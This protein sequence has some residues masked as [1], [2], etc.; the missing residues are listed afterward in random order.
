MVLILN[1]RV[2]L[3]TL[4]SS[5]FIFKTIVVFPELSSP[6]QPKKPIIHLLIRY[7]D[8]DRD[9]TVDGYI[10][11]EDAHFFLFSLDFSN[12]AKQPHCLAATKKQQQQQQQLVGVYFPSLCL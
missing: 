7:R 10:H 8:R 9:S 5:P 4:V 3:I 12:D 2:G 6:L 1:P 11:H